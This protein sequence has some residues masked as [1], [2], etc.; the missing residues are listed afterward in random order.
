[1]SPKAMLYKPNSIIFFKGDVSDR[2]FILNSGKVSL[3]YTDIETGQEVH[4]LIATGEFF[5]V[6]SA[7]GRYPREETAVVLTDSA[8]IGFTVP[9]FEQLA[10]QKTRIIM[11][12]LRVFSNQLRRVHKRVQ[13]MLELKDVKDEV[14]RLR[15]YIEKMQSDNSV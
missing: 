13:N 6:K 5:G 11:K 4:D 9:E 3:N 12:M 1:M 2:I 8:V 14:N 10:M 15:L 7:L